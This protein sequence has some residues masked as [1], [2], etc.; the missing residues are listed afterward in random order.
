MDDNE[1]RLIE[2]ECASNTVRFYR[3]L[4][5][6]DGPAAALLF[7]EDGVWYRDG[8]DSGYTGRAAIADNVT[9]SRERGNP[10]IP[11]ED[12][13]VVHLVTNLEVTVKDDNTAEV[14]AHTTIIA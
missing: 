14:Q 4:D 11:P 8:D 5:A 6:A 1:R 9:K 10:S 2:F 3:R 7:A 13:I 12:R